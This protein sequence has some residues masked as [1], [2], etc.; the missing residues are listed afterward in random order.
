MKTFQHKGRT[1]TRIFPSP[2]MYNS[3]TVREATNRGDI[4]AMNVDTQ[5]FTILPGSGKTEVTESLLTPV[6]APAYKQLKL[7]L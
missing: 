1:Y 4:F 7:K 6:G 2:R 5:Q 3:L